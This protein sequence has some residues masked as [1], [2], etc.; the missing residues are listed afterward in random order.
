MFFLYFLDYRNALQFVSNNY[1]KEQI[2]K[3]S[4]AK[5][6][7]EALLIA[8]QVSEILL[9]IKGGKM[10][11]AAKPL[12]TPARHVNISYEEVFTNTIRRVLYA[13]RPE[14]APTS[15]HH[16][17]FPKERRHRSLLIVVEPTFLEK[18]H[19]TIADEPENRSS[20]EK[21]THI[22]DSWT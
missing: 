16:F 9:L 19:F 13:L 12:R 10:S 21:R 3:V 6:Y 2:N 20:F 14:G 22:R 11:C 17:H 1:F 7:L 8:F 15:A 5:F 4:G 18:H